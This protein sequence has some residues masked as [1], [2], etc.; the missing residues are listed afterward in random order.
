VIKKRDADEEFLE[1]RAKKKNDYLT[2]FMKDL[3]KNCNYIN[4]I[5]KTDLDYIRTC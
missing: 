1:A 3:V 2:K 4:Q 5:I